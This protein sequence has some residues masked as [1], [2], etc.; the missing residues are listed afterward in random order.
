MPD[1][2]SDL[3]VVQAFAEYE[4]QHRPGVL[5]SEELPAET[6]LR[7]PGRRPD[8]CNAACDRAVELGLVRWH[9]FDVAQRGL[10]EQGR[11]LLAAAATEQKQQ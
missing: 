11:A 9:A 10:T 1:G 6:L 3:D 2:I 5:G 4:R 8:E 7:I